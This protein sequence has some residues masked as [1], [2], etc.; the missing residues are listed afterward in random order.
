VRG[1]G[2]EGYVS[3]KTF[4]WRNNMLNPKTTR[5]LIASVTAA[6]SVVSVTLWLSAPAASSE[7][8]EYLHF[9][10]NMRGDYIAA[11]SAGFNLADVST[12]PA[13]RGLPEGMKGIYWLGSGYNS[14]R[15]SCS[16]RL[17]DKQ[18]TETVTAIR[19]NRK[20]SGIYYISDEPHP[21]L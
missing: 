2:N 15:T 9:A 10:A 8:R 18:V 21:A 20:F 1:I 14:R 19:D 13:L 4:A 17:S 3:L 12:Q 7:P 5:V 16:W 11:G 6:L